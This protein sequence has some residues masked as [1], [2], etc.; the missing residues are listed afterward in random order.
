[1]PTYDN[2]SSLDNVIAAAIEAWKHGEGDLDDDDL[3]DDIAF[4]L[5]RA[6]TALRISPPVQLL[7]GAA[8]DEM[9]IE[10][11]RRLADSSRYRDRVL[12]LLQIGLAEEYCTSTGEMA[13]RCLEL[14]G[15]AF[16]GGPD[17]GAYVT[18]LTRCYI[19]GFF[20][21]TIIVAGSVLEQ[22]LSAAFLRAKLPLPAASGKSPIHQQIVFAQKAK[23]LSA[24]GAAAA[25]AVWLRRC[26]A[27]HLDPEL[28]TQAADTVRLLAVVCQQLC[29]VGLIS[30][31]AIIAMCEKYD[32][33]AITRAV[34]LAH[35]AMMRKHELRM[36]RKKDP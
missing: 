11:A 25:K 22:E 29:V 36:R 32:V 21:E 33:P 18:L 14:S 10:E 23:W 26:K 15:C 13:Q 34:L 16:P 9:E 2:F 24:E 4:A 7:G 12:S 28:V 8:S 20:P 27:V 5:S 3:V 31:R 17:A 19:M 1:M 35:H 30:E 6:A